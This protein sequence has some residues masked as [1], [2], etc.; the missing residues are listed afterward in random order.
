MIPNSIMTMNATGITTS[1]TYGLRGL[2]EYRAKSFMFTASV[3]KLPI[4]AFTPDMKAHPSLAPRYSFPNWK[5][6]SPPPVDW[7]TQPTIAKPA[8][9][10]AM[11]LARKIQCRRCVGM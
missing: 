6:W 4:M 2:R 7:I 1:C 3:A 8:T 10:Q 11:A 5:T 9:G